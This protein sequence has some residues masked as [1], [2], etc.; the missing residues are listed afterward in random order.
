VT[1]R[2]AA[3]GPLAWEVGQAGD[4]LAVSDLGCDGTLEAVLLRPTTGELF[5]F[6]GWAPPGAPATATALPRAVPASGITAGPGGCGL[7]ASLPD[8]SLA[9]LDAEL[10]A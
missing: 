2:S 6:D 10:F 9:P 4:V 5:V 8:G 7:V 1:D 3:I